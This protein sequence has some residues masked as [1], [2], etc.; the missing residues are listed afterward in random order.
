ML[1]E[2]R[3]G[4]DMERLISKTIVAIWESAGHFIGCGGLV[5]RVKGAYTISKWQII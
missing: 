2:I 5:L 1:A 3:L 4:N